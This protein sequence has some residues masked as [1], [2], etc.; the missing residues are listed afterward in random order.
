M[1]PASIRDRLLEHPA[2]IVPVG[3]TE[4]HGPHLPLGCDTI[5]VERLADDLS[6]ASGWMRAPTVEYGVH[7]PT[8]SF[9][10]WAAL[11]RKTLHGVMNELIES[12]EE[13]AGVRHFLI[14][15]AQNNDAHQEALSTIR[16]DEASV[17]AVDIFAMDFSTVIERP[18]SPVQGGE[19][20]TSLM[21]YVAPDLV[22]MELAQDFAL[23]TT[24]R[25]RFRPGH[26]RELPKGSPGSIGYPSLASA[27]K[28][29]RVYSLIF[30]RVSRC[31]THC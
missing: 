14:L 21:L 16:A 30:E 5:I 13:G 4:Q 1:T 20:D 18:G 28:G 31:L 11:R 3:T 6:A 22:H 17:V 12:W 19:L 25:S 29:E 23:P 15:T 8:R 2:L 10:G 24:G 26:S 27:Q 7:T 9:P